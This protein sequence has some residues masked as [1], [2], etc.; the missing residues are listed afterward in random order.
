M[1]YS[2][3][4]QSKG[5]K[6]LLQSDRED[7]GT[8]DNPTY[9]LG[10]VVKCPPGTCRFMG[11]EKLYFQQPPFFPLSITYTPFSTNAANGA[12]TFVYLGAN[13]SLQSTDFSSTFTFDNIPYPVTLANI[14]YDEE[15]F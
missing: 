8:A 7:Y 1:S 15:L 4:A 6:I 9:M 13:V 3:N 12:T 14:G 2:F 10:N 5:A 11:I